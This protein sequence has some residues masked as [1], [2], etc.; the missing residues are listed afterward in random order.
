MLA[1]VACEL[2]NFD[3]RLEVS[4]KTREE[5][6]AKGWLQAVDLMDHEKVC[7]MA[8]QGVPYHVKRTNEGMLRTLSAIEKRMSSD[9][10]QRMNTSNYKLAPHFPA[11]LL[12]KLETN[13]VST[14]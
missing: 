7:I 14:S 2:R 3:V 9:A 11:P 6:F 5:N 8:Q 1:H 12:I 4:L 10:G 13:M